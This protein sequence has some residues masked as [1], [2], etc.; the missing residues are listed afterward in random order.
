M[1]K[2]AYDKFCN[3][4]WLQNIT[5]AETYYVNLKFIVSYLL[6]REARA[7]FDTDM[8]TCKPFLLWHK[9]HS[10]SI[11]YYPLQILTLHMLSCCSV[12]MTWKSSH[13]HAG[14]TDSDKSGEIFFNG[15]QFQ[16]PP[17]QRLAVEQIS[18][19]SGNLFH[20]RTS[21]S[22]AQFWNDSKIL[23]VLFWNPY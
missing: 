5:S 2:N 8:S 1:Y 4:E 3:V 15:R 12:R 10:C 17:R 16:T 6:K 9:V 22:I 18:K 7:Y 23:F 19:P 14:K 13:E 21:L 20:R 11:L